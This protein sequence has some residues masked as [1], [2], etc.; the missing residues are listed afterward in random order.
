MPSKTKRAILDTSAV[1]TQQK[2]EF[3]CR[4]TRST[5]STKTKS[6]ENKIVNTVDEKQ[7]KCNK[8]RTRK[9]SILSE[10]K[11]TVQLQIFSKTFI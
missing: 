4:K 10:Y 8:G 7:E 2:I 3:P 1:D 6:L 11:F 9:R 5:R